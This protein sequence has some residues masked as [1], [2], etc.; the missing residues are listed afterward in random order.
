[1]KLNKF[2]NNLRLKKTYL[3]NCPGLRGGLNM[4]PPIEPI[5]PERNGSITIPPLTLKQHEEFGFS[6]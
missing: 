5:P 2:C 3:G 4:S 6:L 1:M